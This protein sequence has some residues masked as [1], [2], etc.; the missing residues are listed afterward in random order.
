MRYIFIPNERGDKTRNGLRGRLVPIPANAR[1]AT[2]LAAFDSLDG[3]SDVTSET[4]AAEK[5]ALA[6]E[7]AEFMRPVLEAAKSGGR[8]A[9][10][11]TLGEALNGRRKKFN[12]GRVAKKNE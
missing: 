7:R 3:V 2:S 9:A 4:L 11:R 6:A 10:A 5:E 8:E 1:A 12:S